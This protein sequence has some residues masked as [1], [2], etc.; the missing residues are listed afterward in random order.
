M[1][2][3]SYMDMN[4]RINLFA[5]ANDVISN[6][7][8][9][10]KESQF[11]EMLQLENPGCMQTLDQYIVHIFRAKIEHSAPVKCWS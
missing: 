9:L 7:D 3:G 2:C 6:F 1:S 11:I 4:P 5:C 10:N 8:H